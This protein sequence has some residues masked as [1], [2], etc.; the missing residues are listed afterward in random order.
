[1]LL[2]G[3]PFGSPQEERRDP[4]GG[5]PAQCFVPLNPLLIPSCFQSPIRRTEEH[6]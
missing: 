1:M 5:R 6:L 3:P 2:V 4:P